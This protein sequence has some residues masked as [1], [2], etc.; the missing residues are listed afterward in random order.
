MNLLALLKLDS[1]YLKNIG[2]QSSGTILAQLVNIASLPVI[3]R[4]YDPVEIGIFNL[5]MQ[6]LAIAT[7]L[8]S[9]RVEHVV[10]AC[11]VC[12]RFRR[13][14]LPHHDGDPSRA[15]AVRSDSRDV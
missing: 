9:F 10:T 1:G 5:F 4:L 12:G 15:R 7:I 14:V 2:F 8:I 6:A 11:W 3:A 13:C